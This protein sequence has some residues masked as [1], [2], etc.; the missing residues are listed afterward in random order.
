MTKTIE[1]IRKEMHKIIGTC[2]LSDPTWDEWDS[3]IE[4]A[5]NS[6]LAIKVGGEVWF[7]VAGKYDGKI[8]RPQTVRDKLMEGG[9]EPL[10]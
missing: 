2:F 3:S 4:E 1:E 5:K 9:D 6:I 8:S 7:E 10:R